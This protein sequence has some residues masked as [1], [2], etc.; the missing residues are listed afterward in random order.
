MTDSLGSSAEPPWWAAA[1]VSWSFLTILPAP[2]V[3]VRPTTLAGAV[4]LFPLV[5]ALA[6]L[7][8]GGL[9]LVLDHVLPRGP[10]AVLLLAVGVLA[11]GGLHLDGLMDTADG[12]FGGRSPERRLEIMRD[13]RVGAFG[14]AAGTLALLG[15]YAGLAELTGQA[16][17]LALVAALAA[18]RWGMALAIASFPAARTSGL[19]AAFHQAGARR[20]TLLA[21]SALALGIGVGCGLLGLLALVDA[22]LV[23]LAGGRFLVARL[24]GLTG[25]TY[26]ALAVI[27]EILTLYL[28]VA[29]PHLPMEVPRCLIWCT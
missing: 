11:T 2:A 18:S 28:A 7:A 14:V 20:L 5:G 10:V 24:G 13:S 25:D 1:A 27:A 9:G 15:E 29:L 12:V 23:V 26:G 19:G 4:A 22:A 6:G 17:L 16:R 8:L 3:A 21:A